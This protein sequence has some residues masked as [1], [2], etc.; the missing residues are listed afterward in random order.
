[1]RS[2]EAPPDLVRDCMR[3]GRGIDITP[4]AA[5][6]AGHTED[7][8]DALATRLSSNELAHLFALPQSELPG[9]PLR[10]RV[11]FGLTAPPAGARSIVLGQVE[12]RDGRLLADLPISADSLNRNT[13]VV[14]L[15]GSG[16]TTTC[17]RLLTTTWMQLGVP[18]LVVEPVKTEYRE[19]ALHTGLTGRLSVFLPRQVTLRPY[20]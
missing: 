3:R 20:D 7:V 13:F 19:L 8:F 16:K 15:V 9:L 12:D 4:R 18:F 11:D 14:G 2:I 6:Q 5:N 17:K 1:M 10:Q